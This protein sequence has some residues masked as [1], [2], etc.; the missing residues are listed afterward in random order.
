MTKIIK[1]FYNKKRESATVGTLS[2]IFCNM[3]ISIH[4]RH[5]CQ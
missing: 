2:I 1:D 4:T 3:Y 5:Y